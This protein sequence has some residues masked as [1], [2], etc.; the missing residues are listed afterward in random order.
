MQR[1]WMRRLK[2]EEQLSRPNTDIAN[3]LLQNLTC[4]IRKKP[5]SRYLKHIYK[6]SE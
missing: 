3:F 6:R 2:I 4:F 5:S 1:L